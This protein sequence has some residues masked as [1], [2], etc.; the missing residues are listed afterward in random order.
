M[1]S[2]PSISWYDADNS[3]RVVAVLLPAMGV[4][5]RHYK[6]FAENLAQRGLHVAV[7]ELRGQGS[8]QPRP[9]R[10]VD[11]GFYELTVEDVAT[12]LREVRKVY[13][14]A[15][16]AL[17]GHSLGGHIATLYTGIEGAIP[18]SA[19]VTIAADSPYF[20]CFGFRGPLVL[21]S[22]HAAA[23]VSRLLG[24]FPGELP[25]LRSLGVQPR[26]LM[27]EWAALARSGR[28]EIERMPEIASRIASASVPVLSISVEDDPIAPRASVDHLASMFHNASPVRWHYTKAGASA[29]KLNHVRW[30]KHSGALA[31]RV[32]EWLGQVC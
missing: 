29:D 9:S 1:S 22:T 10:K 2:S 11:H 4:A 25:G 12:T 6:P 7:S 3:A 24:Y 13:L 5:A 20:R 8:Y 16:I 32:H 15:P 28:Y 31:A 27:T 17:I 19:V 14:N 30:I 26:T 18:V 23:F 21:A